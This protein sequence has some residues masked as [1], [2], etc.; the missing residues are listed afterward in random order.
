MGIRTRTTS[1]SKQ[2]ILRMNRYRRRQPCVPD[3]GQ[4]FCYS[5]TAIRTSQAS[6]ID[7]YAGGFGIGGGGNHTCLKM[8]RVVMVSVRLFAALQCVLELKSQTPVIDSYA[9]GLGIVAKHCTRLVTARRMMILVGRFAALQWA[10]ELE[11]QASIVD[12][13]AKGVGVVGEKRARLERCGNI[14]RSE[15]NE[16]KS[17]GATECS[18]LHKCVS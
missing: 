8:A 18:E 11:L 9:G 5:A 13:Y 6:V 7:S 15:T 3:E 16:G 12:S 14:G 1:I 17:N 10:L 2:F 4:S